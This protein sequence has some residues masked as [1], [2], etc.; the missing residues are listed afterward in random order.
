MKILDWLNKSENSL[1]ILLVIAVISMTYPYGFPLFS[2]VACFIGILKL[3][4]GRLKL[5]INIG[6]ILL[7]INVLLYFWG[8]TLTGGNI[9]NNNFSD[10]TNI[11]TYFI[12]WILLS[13]LEYENY[14]ILLDKVSKYVLLFSFVISIIALYKF[15][16]LINGIRL[17]QYFIG[18]DYP[19]GTSL[20]RDYNMFSLALSIGLI[21]GVYRLTKS[22]KLFNIFYYLIAS[23]TIASTILFAGSRRGWIVLGLVTLFL[24][25]LLIKN[26]LRTHPVKIFKFS[27]A[28]ISIFLFLY[29]ANSVW[30]IEEMVKNSVQFQKLQFRF[31]TLTGILENS[32]TESL[33]SR[34]VRW[35]YAATLYNNSNIFE[36]FFGSGFDYLEKFGSQFAKTSEDYPHSPFYSALL[37]SGI[38]GLVSLLSLLIFTAVKLL[39]N[40]KQTPF[41]FTLSVLICCLFGFVSSNSIFSINLFF[42]L[43]M[44]AI[45]IPQQNTKITKKVH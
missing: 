36:M 12:V 4:T 3:F 23:L 10:I 35:D 11:F 42:I 31:S 41:Y 8:M 40:I 13:D 43:L 21:S 14:S 39:R 30:N 45:S 22:V 34:S 1:M 6:L 44:V 37:Y 28:A 29:L 15:S 32:D 2:I 19:G 33:S 20:V 5:R 17:E 24:I 18:G 9:Y 16:L 26:I 27:F 25:A 38:F 7:F